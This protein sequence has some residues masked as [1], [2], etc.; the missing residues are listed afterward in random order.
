MNTITAE[1]ALYPQKT[2]NASEIINRSVEAIDKTQVKCQVNDMNTRITG[3]NLNVFNSLK[4]LFQ[5]A[6]AN[7]PEVNMVVT[8]TNA[9][10]DESGL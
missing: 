3:S 2:D 10:E 9:A 4:D 6:E 1:V 8:I 5:E 7:S